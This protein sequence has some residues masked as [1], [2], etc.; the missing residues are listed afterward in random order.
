M[1]YIRCPIILHFIYLMVLN[2]RRLGFSCADIKRGL[3]FLNSHYKV[4][5][6]QPL[7]SELMRAA[8]L[9]YKAPTLNT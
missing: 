3:S 1:N 5:K 4:Q 2:P 6:N 7:T 8:R 9:I